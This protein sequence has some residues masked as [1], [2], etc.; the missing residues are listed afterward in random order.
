MHHKK[1]RKKTQKDGQRHVHASHRSIAAIDHISI[2]S[3]ILFILDGIY[4]CKYSQFQ[5]PTV[6][7]LFSSTVSNLQSNKFHEFSYD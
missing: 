5:T 1:N 3:F 4:F 6:I 2:F 7:G